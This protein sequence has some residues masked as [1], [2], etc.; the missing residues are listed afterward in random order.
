MIGTIE[1][2]VLGTQITA[3]LEDDGKWVCPDVPALEAYLNTWWA[4][5]DRPALGRFGIAYLIDAAKRLE[6]T[7]HF[8]E[9]DDQLPE[10]TVY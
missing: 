9:V 7:A 10:G 5:E 1:V 4:P 2:P 6:G 8:Q 3:T